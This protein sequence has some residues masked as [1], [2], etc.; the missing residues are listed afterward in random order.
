MLGKVQHSFQFQPCCSLCCV[1]TVVAAG[2]PPII[3]SVACSQMVLANVHTLPRVPSVQS[4]VY[5]IVLH[6]P[7]VHSINIFGLMQT[8]LVQ[9]LKSTHGVDDG[10]TLKTHL[11]MTR[12][13]KMLD[14]WIANKRLYDVPATITSHP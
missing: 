7:K 1:R 6:V 8:W 14:S 12:L 4:L 5:T 3:N 9:N 2:A 10:S 11:W 13:W